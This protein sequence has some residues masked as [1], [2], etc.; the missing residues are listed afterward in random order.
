MSAL[1]IIFVPTGKVLFFGWV[2]LERAVHWILYYDQHAPGP[3]GA[4]VE[5]RVS[6]K[7]W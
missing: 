5:Q 2:T 7:D 3:I 4:E 6:R 1:K